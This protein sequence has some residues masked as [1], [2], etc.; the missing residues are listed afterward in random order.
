MPRSLLVVFAVSVATLFTFAAFGAQADKGPLGTI[1]VLDAGSANNALSNCHTCT[2]FNLLPNHKVSLQSP[3]SGVWYCL[4]GSP[5]CAA[6][7]PGIWL[8]PGPVIDDTVRR[9]LDGGISWGLIS[10]KCATGVSVCDLNVFDNFANVP[11]SP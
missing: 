10:I 1:A 6:G 5:T 2:A 11:A 7:Y 9:R 3:D 4:D 8:A